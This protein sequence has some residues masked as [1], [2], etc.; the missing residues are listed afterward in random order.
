MSQNEGTGQG[1][2]PKAPGGRPGAMTMAMQA[3]NIKPVG[4]KVLRIGVIQGGKIVEE[5]IVRKRE[6]VTVG[7]SE[8]NHFVLNAAGITPRFELFQ[9]VGADYILNFTETMTGRVGLPAGVQ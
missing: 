8:R 7:S 6:T 4:P 2:Q 1:A 5:R 9:L 3:V